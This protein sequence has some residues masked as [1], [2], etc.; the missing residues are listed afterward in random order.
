MG[1]RGVVPEGG[2]GVDSARQAICYRFVFAWEFARELGDTAGGY[3]NPMRIPQMPASDDQTKA[4][5]RPPAKKDCARRQRLLNRLAG[6]PRCILGPLLD[7]TTF[8]GW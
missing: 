3:G 6:C 8:P 2:V 5:V 7:P 1:A 4:G